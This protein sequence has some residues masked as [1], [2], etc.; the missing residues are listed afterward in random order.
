M[1]PETQQ[2]EGRTHSWVYLPGQCTLNTN[3]S[4]GLVDVNANL[5]YASLSTFWLRLQK[6]RVQC[7][8]QVTEESQGKFMLSGL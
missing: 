8:D 5:Y 1:V 2:N 7:H 4:F 6:I 3:N